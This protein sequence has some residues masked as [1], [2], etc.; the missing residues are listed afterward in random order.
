MDL[1]A[2][3][4]KTSVFNS[5]LSSW[6][7]ERVENMQSTFG[8]AT[9]FNSYV[10]FLKK[11]DNVDDAVSDWV[12]EVADRRIGKFGGNCEVQLIWYWY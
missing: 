10:E 3:F 11:S 7:V 1:L 5:D 12:G 4:Y 2:T 9:S 6:N 8:Y